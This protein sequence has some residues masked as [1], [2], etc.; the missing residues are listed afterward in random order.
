MAAALLLFPAAAV[1]HVTLDAPDGGEVLD[2]GSQVS[3]EW[4]VLIEHNTENWDLWYSTTGADGPW[5]EVAVDLPAGNTAPGSVHSFAWTVPDDPSTAVRVRVR[6]D[7]SGTDYLDVSD[8]DLAI[9]GQG[10]IFADAFEGGD[11]G[12]WA[13][14]P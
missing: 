2:V 1:A 5:I 9:E 3:I 13:A 11:T 4:R 10:A 7:N 12:A 8:A 14:G 6:Q